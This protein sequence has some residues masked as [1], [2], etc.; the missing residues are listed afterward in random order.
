MFGTNLKAKGGRYVTIHLVLCRCRQGT[1][2]Q[3]PRRVIHEVSPLDLERHRSIF[4]TYKYYNVTETTFQIN[5]Y[6]C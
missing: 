4:M 2:Y 5:K 3:P 1:D 6:H